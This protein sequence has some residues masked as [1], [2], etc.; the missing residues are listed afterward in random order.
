M[1]LTKNSLQKSN[2]LYLSQGNQLP[3]RIT[4][5]GTNAPNQLPVFRGIVAVPGRQMECKC[6]PLRGAAKVEFCCHPPLFWTLEKE[7]ET[8]LGIKKVSRPT[9]IMACWF[10]I[11]KMSPRIYYSK[12]HQFGNPFLKCYA[13][14]ALF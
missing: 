4:S 2:I 14:E 9:S 7:A 8:N 5:S 3:Y 10:S 6:I 1:E 11:T 12:S 13:V